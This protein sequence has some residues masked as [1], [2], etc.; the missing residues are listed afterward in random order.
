LLLIPSATI[1]AIAS[2]DPPAEKGTTRVIGRVGQSCARGMGRIDHAYDGRYS[3]PKSDELVHSFHFHLLRTTVRHENSTEISLLASDQ[4][5]VA[6][7][8]SPS[9]YKFP[10]R[11]TGIDTFASS[12]R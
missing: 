9:A 3:Y 2:L 12:S 10:R 7:R 4:L 5:T 8:H 6:R 1:R 11:R